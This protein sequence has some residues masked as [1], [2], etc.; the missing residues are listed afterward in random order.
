VNPDREHATTPIAALLHPIGGPPG[1]RLGALLDGG[2][3]PVASL[4]RITGG[5]ERIVA[6][7]SGAGAAALRARAGLSDGPATPEALAVRLRR[8][9]VSLSWGAPHVVSD[10]RELLALCRARGRF[11]VELARADPS[12]V[13]EMQLGGWFDARWRLRA[14]R[15]LVPDLR[16]A[17]A[18][19][20]MRSSRSLAVAADL[21]FWAGVRETATAPEWQRLTRSSYVVL[22]YH[23]FAGELKPG[24]ERFDIA[25]ARFDR[26]MRFLRIAGFKA[27]NVD[28]ILAFH[29][30][31]GSTLSARGF[32]ITVDDALLDCVGPLRRHAGLTPLLFVCTG[33][34]GGSAHWL[35]REPIATWSDVIELASAG[36]AVASH[37][38]RHVRLTPLTA[39]RRTEEL[40]GSL[41]DLRERLVGPAEVVA[42][43]F[44]DHDADVCDAARAAGYRAGFTTEKGRNGA[45]MDSFSLRRVS[46]HGHDGAL[47]VL[48]KVITGEPLPGP[49]LRLRGLRSWRRPSRGGEDRSA[50]A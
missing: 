13:S 20:V 29:A 10:L 46:V 23:R 30:G 50:H 7:V 11:S 5:F 8:D 28:E 49:W 34:L 48:W 16:G 1:S 33:E 14:L 31:S 45:G 3:Q 43:P 32:A 40:S 25:P 47:A 36:V 21:A 2:L 15:R 27:L 18:D 35:D 12:L 41:A 9:G 39:I 38:R 26:Q 22:A 19:V 44:G 17:A 42:Y 37:G 4:R 6:A 24:Q